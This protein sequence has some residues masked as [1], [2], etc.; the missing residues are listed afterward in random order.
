MFRMPERAVRNLTR[1]ARLLVW[2]LPRLNFAEMWRR[3][4]SSRSDPS[5][6]RGPLPYEII[7]VGVYP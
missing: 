1:G 4:E 5:L 3:A 2:G 7:V 6:L